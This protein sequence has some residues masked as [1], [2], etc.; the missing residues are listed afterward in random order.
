[1]STWTDIR[2]TIEKVAPYAL[3]ALPGAGPVVGGI[4]SMALGTKNDPD[5]V[6]QA[7]QADPQAADKIM[8]YQVQLKAIVAN[9][10][11]ADHQAAVALAQTDTADRQSARGLAIAKGFTP[12]VALSALF[13]GGYFV[14][15][16]QFIL[17]YTHLDPSYKDLLLTLIGVL[18]A[19]IPQILN[20][21]FGSSHGSQKKDDA[22]AQAALS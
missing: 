5:S 17:G 18:T 19:G 13:V 2:D 9:Q 12:Q 20:F 3:S 15:L 14:L 16:A 10:A 11:V 7:I 22:L 21:W 6:Q 1:M 8:A 4:L